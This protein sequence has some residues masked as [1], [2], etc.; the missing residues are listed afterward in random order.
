MLN[1][2]DIHVGVKH[3]MQLGIKQAVIDLLFQDTFPPNWTHYNWTSQYRHTIVSRC[4]DIIEQ[5]SQE[6]FCA[7]NP[8]YCEKVHATCEALVKKVKGEEEEQEG[9]EWPHN[10]DWFDCEDYVSSFTCYLFNKAKICAPKNGLLIRLETFIE[11]EA[12]CSS[13][14]LGLCHSHNPVHCFHIC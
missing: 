3:I 12:P 7:H 2:T 14:C 1:S 13:H 5:C 9:G 11:R 8:I 10:I 6:D 4:C